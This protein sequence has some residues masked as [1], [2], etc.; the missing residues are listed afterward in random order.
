MSAISYVNGFWLD[1][2]RICQVISQLWFNHPQK[3][4]LV[5]IA[6]GVPGI[7]DLCL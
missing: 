3:L 7:Q 4:N 5:A 1:L 2:D 6:C